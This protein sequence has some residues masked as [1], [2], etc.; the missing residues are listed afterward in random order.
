MR[1]GGYPVDCRQVLTALSEKPPI[2]RK[3]VHLKIKVSAAS[4][5]PV[6]GATAGIHAVQATGNRG[7]EFEQFGARDSG[8]KRRVSRNTAVA[9]RT[10]RRLALS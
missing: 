7:D 10:V 9:L 6:V 1:A 8:L 2:I 3:A 5:C 4:G